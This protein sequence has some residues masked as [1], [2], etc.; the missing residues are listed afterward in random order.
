MKPMGTVTGRRSMSMISKTVAE[1]VGVSKTKTRKATSDLCTFMGIPH[2]SRS[3]I[4]TIISKFIKLYSA[5]LLSPYWLML[6]L[7]LLSYGKYTAAYKIQKYEE[8]VDKSLKSD[9]LHATAQ[10]DKVFEQQK[11]FADL[12][13]NIE[14]LEK[15]S[16]TSLR[17]LVNIGSSRQLAV[18]PVALVSLLVSNVLG[19]VADSFSEVYIELAILLALMFLSVAQN[20]LK[21]LTMASQPRLQVLAASKN[22][23]STL[24]G[25]PYLPVLEFS[26][27][28][29]VLGS[30]M[31]AI[32]LVMKH[33][34]KSR[35]YLRFLR[36]AGPLTAVVLG[37]LFVK[38]F[39]PPSISLMANKATE[40]ASKNHKLKH[41]KRSTQQISSHDATPHTMP[42]ITRTS[43]NTHTNTAPHI[44]ESFDDVR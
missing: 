44:R 29:F 6:L 23:I 8:F 10:R 14:N 11:I 40:K 39:H 4:S 20:K 1:I 32:L 42:S 34:G 28:P 26:W 27:P 31:L 12:R 16:V 2:H 7:G 17:T 9:L 30:V 25:F 13:R 15:N 43:N 5:R 3:E 35:K 18:G 41:L 19:S 37:T 38:I 22:R 21:S 24:K 33:L 36:A